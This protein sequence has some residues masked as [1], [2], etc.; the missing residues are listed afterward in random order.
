MFLHRNFD[1]SVFVTAKETAWEIEFTFPATTNITIGSILAVGS[2]D[3]TVSIWD[4]EDLICLRTFG[5]LEYVQITCL[6]A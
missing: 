5:R 3:A 1:V 4:A 2:A 6:L